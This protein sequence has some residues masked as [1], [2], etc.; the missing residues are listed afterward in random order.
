MTPFDNY[1]VKAKEAVHRAHQLAVERGQNQ[2]SPLHL[3]AALLEQDESMVLSILDHLEIDTIELSD[4]VLDILD[5]SASGTVMSPSFQLYLTPELAHVFEA[6]TRIAASF[7]EKLVSTE[8]LL[9]G[10]LE[11]PGPAAE[12]FGRYRLDKQT[13]G[14]VL[15][16]IK[17][18]TITDT[19]EPKRA[20]ALGKYARS[21]TEL[22]LENKLD[23]VIGRDEEVTRVIQ[24]LSRRTKNNPI[25]IGEAGVG[26]TAIAEGLAQRMAS[27]D[28]PESLRGKDLVMLDLGLLIAGTKYRGEFVERLKSV[29][30]E[31]EKSE[32][33]IIL[34]IDE[35]HTLV[36]AGAAEGAMDASNMLKPA[37]ARGELHLIGATTLKEYQK[38]IEHDAAFTRR[39]Q[40]V[41]VNEPSVDDAIAILR[42]LK[43][44]YEL[45]HGVHI[46]D[47]ALIAAVKLSSRYITD[48]R[49]PDK[50][51]DLIDEA[52]SSLRLSLEN[53]PPQLEA[54]H[55][56][57]MRL[58]IEREALKADLES[59]STK[60]KS[61]TK[62]I[63]KEIGDLKE[64][65][66][67]LELKWKNEKETLADIKRI[68]E[69]L[70]G[71][72]LEADGA[73]AA[74]DLTRAA[75]IRYARIPSLEKELDLKQK[76]LKKLQS[77][78]RILKEEIAEQDIAS[79]VARWTGIPVTRMLEEE[80]EKLS[81][82]EEHLKDRVIG[83]D[84]AV[85]LVSDAIKRSRAG[86][87]DPNRPVGSFLFLGPTGVGKTELTKALAEFLF[88]DEQAL[89]RVD[90]SELM[91]R[92]SVSKLIGSPPGYVGYDEGGSLTE[93]VRHRPYSVIL[94]DEIEKAHPEVFNILL[95]V[96]DNGRLTDAKGRTVNFKN[97]VII[98]TSNIGAQYIDTM[99]RLGFGT[100]E[101]R[102]EDATYAQAKEKVM[103]SLKE[104]FRPEFINRLDEI[105]VFNILDSA[106]I[107][108][109]VKLQVEIAVER[110][111]EKEV[112]LAVSPEV[113]AYLAKEGYNPRYGARPLKRLIQSKILTPVANLMISHG[114]MEGGSVAVGMKD[115]ELSIDVQKRERATPRKKALAK[116]K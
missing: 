79:I 64:E 28:V 55:R 57:I 2:V 51:I 30:K 95:Q 75:E 62:A 89:I 108:K 83:Q 105:I 50:A 23:P 80:A 48:R 109:I 7:N 110:L 100:A 49:L 96:L 73:E 19:E 111:K 63:E 98:L 115:G 87:A 74:A 77:S 39:F 35:I 46:T 101:E 54:A 37:L 104:Y 90:M 12:V 11:Y 45:F 21:L 82:M 114:V 32:G 13:V 8:H 103:D 56:Q 92:H 102:T 99:S 78:R 26:K 97:S 107:E 40:P 91:E 84:E 52:S 16:D 53:K 42:G 113:L 36:G 27:G 70:E 67:E 81:R 94:F 66:H 72:R 71:L 59:G 44:K 24:I 116:A 60:A 25:L 22:A 88:D 93:A 86:I 5:G 18:G 41:Y 20:R 10:V 85:R 3:F 34:F 29:M 68:K 4:V 69:E 38:H 76:R 65:T 112:A 106:S 58:E 33:N 31:V 9:L 17:D 15:A 43:E 14:R 47:D 1:T 6:S 61:R